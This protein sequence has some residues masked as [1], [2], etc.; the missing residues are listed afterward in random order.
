MMRSERD[1]A[2]G[3]R[4]EEEEEEEGWCTPNKETL[5]PRCAV[6]VPLRELR[7]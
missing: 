1:T 5:L 7:Y 2:D 6:L 4:E 3:A